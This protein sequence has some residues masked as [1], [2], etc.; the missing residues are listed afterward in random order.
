MN[1]FISSSP[2]FC[3]IYQMIT[4]EILVS[5]SLYYF[6]HSL[7]ASFFMKSLIEKISP[8]LNKY[9]RIFYN[10]FSVLLLL[11]LYIRAESFEKNLLFEKNVFS[12][13]IAFILLIPG[14]FILYKSFKNYDKREFLGL[15]VEQNNKG[16]LNIGGLNAYFRH[17][18]YIGTILLFVGF[19]LL[20]PHL[21]RFLY[22]SVSLIYLPI[23]SRLEE[24]KLKKVFGEA[25][26]S[27]L[28][29]VK[30]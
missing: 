8:T 23:G 13:S 4:F 27:Y 17:P 11:L 10:V 15:S 18:L 28:K 24:I 19:F 3:Y 25:Y 16:Q 1:F 7:L 21:N 30:F 22:V 29:K 26:E 9:Y 2:I 6:L 5:W 20:N 12:T 14:I